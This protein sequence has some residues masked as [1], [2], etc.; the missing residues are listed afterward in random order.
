MFELADKLPLESF[1][2]AADIDVRIAPTT[3]TEFRPAD[4]MLILD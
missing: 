2:V 3:G 4:M 1:M